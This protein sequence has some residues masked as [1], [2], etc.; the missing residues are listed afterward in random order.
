MAIHRDRQKQELS[1]L[2]IVA[3][4]G[5]ALFYVVYSVQ[6]TTQGQSGGTP[7]TILTEADD[8]SSLEKDLDTLDND[9]AAPEL[10]QLQNITDK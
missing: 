9:P 7:V 3:L 2:I 5:A 10:S 6:K 4:L 1:I 8:V